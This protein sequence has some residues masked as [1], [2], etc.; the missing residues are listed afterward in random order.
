MFENITNWAEGLFR[1]KKDIEPLKEP[2]QLK[3]ENIPS[4]RVS[5][6]NDDK[7]QVAIM[8]GIKNLLTPSFRTELIPLIRDLYKV[9]PEMS[10]ALQDMFKLTNTGHTI[11]FDNNTPEE[12]R[13]MRKHLE[14]VQTEW[15][16]YTFGIDG[17]VNKLILQA[18]IGGAMSYEAVPKNDLSGI[19]TILF[20][21]PEDINFKRESQGKYHPYQ[22]N[23][24]YYNLVKPYIRLNTSTYKYISIYN[25]TDEP[26]GVPPLLASLSPLKT[27][28][29]MMTNFKQIMEMLGMVGFMEVLIDRPEKRAN[30]SE[31]AYIRRIQ[32]LIDEA[33]R[34]VKAGMK[35]GMVV[36]IKDDHEF[37]MNVTTNNLQNVDSVFKLNQQSVANGLGVN[38]GI[39]GI[40]ASSTEGGQS[41]ALSK[42]IAQ[43]KNLQLAGKFALQHIYSL[44]LVLAGFNNKGCRVEFY[45]PTVTDDI[46]YQ[47][48]R[49]YK[50]RNLNA[51]YVAGIITQDQYALEA[52]YDKPAEKEPRIPLDQLDTGDG[53]QKKKREDGKDTSDRKTRD[54]NKPNP[55]RKDGD[56]K[57]R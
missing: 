41:I 31:S 54:K 15:A 12:A 18:F 43:L 47:Q 55:K 24:N 37:N 40:N 5:V 53:G 49:E 20:I 4:G 6:P 28:E 26:Y 27:Q 9:N 11:H 33:K 35:D 36:G 38:A 3:G 7:T 23:R 2:K 16:K 44:E 56:S 30:E 52:G 22:K 51:L 17:I 29:D 32:L 50:I 14:E 21:N 46:K 57:P 1:V 10:I 39:I 45:T 8:K 25:D 13:K 42:L 19:S 48:A 34:N